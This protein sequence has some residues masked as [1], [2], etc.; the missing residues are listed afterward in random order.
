MHIAAE[1]HFPDLYQPY[2]TEQQRSRVADCAIPHDMRNNTSFDTREYELFRDIFA[3]RASNTKPWGLVSL[4]FE[5][6]TTIPLAAFRQFAGERFAQGSDCVFINPYI[7]LEALYSN[8]W[9]QWQLS[10]REL[11][12]FDL[13]NFLESIKPNCFF[14]ARRYPLMGKDQF[15]FCNY[16]VG[17]QRFWIKYFEFVE[18]VMAALERERS[19]N[20]RVGI[21]YT[22]TV[23]YPR[24]PRI[25]SR[26]FIIERLFSSFVKSQTDVI[27]SSWSW[28]D[29]D[30]AS[31]FGNRLGKHLQQISNLKNRSIE[32][33]DVQS[34]ERWHNLRQAVW[35]NSGHV[36]AK[37][38]DLDAMF[39]QDVI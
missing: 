26:P 11:P 15:A 36:F 29:R 37:L 21:F 6:K 32:F 18:T 8:V 4:S 13:M 2:L 22:G 14:P 1:A 10:N 34:L 9:E 24:D 28:N 3:Q 27:F 7:S 25:T 20:T 23:N 33:R 17:N 35:Q 5:L 19:L 30:Y 39:V 31:K 12:I 16:F 38:D